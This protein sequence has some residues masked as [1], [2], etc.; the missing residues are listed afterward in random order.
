MIPMLHQFYYWPGLAKDVKN[1]IRFCEECQQG[2]K[3]V[4]KK[5]IPMKFPTTV[6]MDIVGPIQKSNGPARYIVTM[7]DRFSRW[8]EAVVTS[9]ISVEIIAKIFYEQ[10]VCRFGIPNF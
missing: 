4:K 2:K 6:H 7:L 9:T 1:H 5:R 10:W 8:L 3:F